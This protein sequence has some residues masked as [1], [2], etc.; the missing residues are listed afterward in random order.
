MDSSKLKEKMGVESIHKASYLLFMLVSDIYQTYQ[1][2]NI[3]I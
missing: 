3:H 2:I 1:S